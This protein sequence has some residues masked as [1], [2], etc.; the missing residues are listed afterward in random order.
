MGGRGSRGRGRAPGRGRGRSVDG[1][2]VSR[3]V[4]K[5]RARLDDIPGE[6]ALLPEVFGVDDIPPASL[7]DLDPRDA[8]EIVVDAASGDEAFEHEVRDV[9]GEHDGV[10]VSA[11]EPSVSPRADIDGEDFV[12][13][14]ADRDDHAEPDFDGD[15]AQKLGLVWA[16]AFVRGPPPLGYFHDRASNRSLARITE[17]KDIVGIKCYMHPKCSL[18]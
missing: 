1:D 5:R 2:G 4:A 15:R 10:D 11:E 9:T 7:E 12:E 3:P 17:W 16:V 14:G 18:A 8:A 13:G 6:V